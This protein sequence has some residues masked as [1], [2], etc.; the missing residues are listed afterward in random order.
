MKHL[1]V[2]DLTDSP[3]PSEADEDRDLQRAIYLSTLPASASV[4]SMSM[5]MSMSSS[6]SRPQQYRPGHFLNHGSLKLIQSCYDTTDCS[7][8]SFDDILQADAGL[9][10]C[11]MS[12]YVIDEEWLTSK[13]EQVPNITIA[14]HNGEDECCLRQ[15]EVAAYVTVFVM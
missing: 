13:I 15:C 3:R 7:K 12:S 2:I 10:D 9:L 5:S 6:S 8:V 1:E 11:I 4:S 14:L